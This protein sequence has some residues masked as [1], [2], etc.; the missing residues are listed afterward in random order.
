MFVA[1]KH[2]MF[3]LRPHLDLLVVG[4]VY[5]VTSNRILYVAAAL[6]NQATFQVSGKTCT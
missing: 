1:R 6:C 2:V 3:S 4:F 5:R